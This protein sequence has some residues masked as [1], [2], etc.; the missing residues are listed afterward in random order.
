MTQGDFKCYKFQYLVPAC[1]KSGYLIQY[2]N[3]FMYLLIYTR[4]YL[5]LLKIIS[6]WS[7]LFLYFRKFSLGSWYP[8]TPLLPTCF[9][10]HVKDL[11]FPCSLIQTIASVI[12]SFPYC[13]R[14]SHT[15]VCVRVCC[16]VFWSLF[17]L[18]IHFFGMLDLSYRLRLI[19]QLEPKPLRY[20]WMISVLVHMQQYLGR[21]WNSI[22]CT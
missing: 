22:N 1:N 6:A 14:H 11:R 12:C 5:Q 16:V 21:R 4:I 18:F 19:W 20:L 7:L 9:K 10:V 3:L 13:L 8:W 17:L 2:S 15:C